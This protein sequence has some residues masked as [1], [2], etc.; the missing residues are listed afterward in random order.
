MAN[1]ST[2][3]VLVSSQTEM[4]AIIENIPMAMMLVDKDRRV[5]LANSAASKFA[6]IPADMM[7]GQ[8]GGEALHCVNSF[9]DPRGCGFSAAC[10]GCLIR[11]SIEASFDQGIPVKR[12]ENVLTV[13]QDGALA[14]L[15]LLITTSPVTIMDERACLICIE[16]VTERKRNEQELEHLA[17]FPRANPNPVIEVGSDG[18]VLFSNQAAMDVLTE[19]DLGDD[20]RVFLPEGFPSILAALRQKKELGVV[21]GEVEIKGRFFSESIHTLDQ[22]DV[23]RIYVTDVTE[24]KKKEMELGRLNRT[25]K[26]MSNSN[27]AMLR[28]TDEQGLLNEVCRIIT[29]DCG[30]A[31]VWVGLA[32]HDENRSVKPVA[33]AGF[34]AGYLETLNV[35]WADTERGQGPTGTAIRTG[36][37]T[38]CKNMLT[39][40]RF[41]LWRD[42]A[43]KRGYASSLVLP[44]KTDGQAFGSLS[45]YFNEPDTC[46]DSELE[47]LIK[48]ADDISYGIT[49]LRLKVA[50]DEAELALKRSEDR[51]RNLFELSPEAMY[52]NRD[53]R[54]E[55]VNSAA[56]KLF[57]AQDLSQ[58][59]GKS[60]FDIFH[61]DCHKQVSE[62]IEKLRNGE[63]AP[64]VEE[65]IIRLD[66]TVRTVEVAAAPFW[67][68]EGLAI[69]VIMRDITEKKQIADSLRKQEEQISQER[70]ILNTILENTSTYLAYLDQDFNF[71]SINDAYA[72]LNKKSKDGLIG[73]NYFEVYP[74]NE[75]REI[76]KAVKETG[77]AAEFKAKPYTFPDEPERGTTYW[78]WRLAPIKDAGG[79]VQGFV[80]SLSDVTEIKRAE[81]E[82][83]DF[84]A[85][86]SHE[87]RNPLTPILTGSQLIKSR[88]EKSAANGEAV[89]KSL[90]EQIGIIEQ[91]SKSL[92]HLLDDLL[93]TT[94]ISQGR[95]QLDIERIDL[96]DCLRN[97]I[98]ATKSLIAM[99]KHTLCI[100]LPQT[101]IYVDADFVR[102]EQIA[103]NLI[104]NAA[105]YTRPHGRIWLEARLAG[106]EAEIVVRDNGIGIDQG[107]IDSIFKLFSRSGTAFVSTQGEMGIGLNLT[108]NLVTMHGGTITAKSGG[109]D[110]GSEF[111]VRLPAA[112]GNAKEEAA[113][114]D[115]PIAS[116]DRAH[117]ILIVD[118]N[119]SIAKL[120]C[121]A[122][123]YF[124]HDACVA[125]D[126]ATAIA[127]FKES[128]PRAALIDIGMPGM[129]GYEIARELRK[130]EAEGGSKVTLIAVTGYGQAEDKLRSKEAGFD[131]HLVKPVDLKVLEEV[132]S[133]I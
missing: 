14:E 103:V 40:P 106:N 115:A 117:H 36:K 23:I 20:V 26:A 51:Y 12:A 118:D 70:E 44:L 46:S 21:F 31:M 79:T 27:L 29:E 47:L 114:Q 68:Q 119:Q 64:L 10:E 97:A 104:N 89:D 111:I 105:K 75:N 69:Q 43:I 56:L 18:E 88:L 71:V 96:V 93:D 95:I 58:I 81:E 50:H 55:F 54:I 123:E 127:M 13:A 78:D 25:L 4:L 90:A 112:S 59:L 2:I 16:D 11:H 80:F 6:R 130:I 3:E 102:I 35:T 76:F 62:R 42:E 49:T 38:T 45:I 32:E 1:Q 86:M 5:H 73:M 53:N 77:E 84:I 30:H 85:I 19:L 28:A 41:E 15:T 107:K 52:V 98:T 131:T 34:E 57:G 101:P 100:S 121:D 129:N 120:L 91:Q 87:L 124:G 37:P 24:R 128:R 83:N 8:R 33:S 67:D 9:K 66:G 116:N 22:L 17:S 132:L 61:P 113:I 99:Q 122:L 63:I 92:N 133:K 125:H 109:A 60:P 94:R 48:L 110:Q 82:K 108:K 126:G 39:D 72:K 65:K 74:E 7:I